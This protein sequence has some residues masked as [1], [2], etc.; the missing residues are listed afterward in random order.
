M[1]HKAFQ[2]NKVRRFINTYGQIFQFDKPGK[3]EFGE[4]NGETVSH[5][6]KGVFHETSEFA[7]G[8]ITKT[9]SDSTTIRLKSNPMFLTLWE[10]VGD[11]KHQDELIFNDK[12]YRIN[13][14][15]NLLQANLIA[16]ISLE[17]VQ[18]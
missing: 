14:V 3:N 16:E 6:I 17:E 8:Y 18:T 15:T 11:L 9:T 4:P 5:K 12:K 13:G 10:S 2:L 7:S 1:N